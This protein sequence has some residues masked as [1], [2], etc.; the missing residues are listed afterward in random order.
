DLDEAISLHQSALDLRPT[1]HSDRS[2][3]LHS[4]ALCFSDRYDKQGAIAD[5]E[6]AITLGRAALALRSPGHS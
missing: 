3:S 2:D 1:G 4:L 5:L 6:E